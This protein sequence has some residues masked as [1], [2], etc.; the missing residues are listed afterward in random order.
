ME[1]NMVT[2]EQIQ[3]WKDKHLCVYLFEVGEKK[4]YF[5]MPTLREVEAAGEQKTSVK[6]AQTMAKSCFLGG[7]D[8]LVNEDRY[9]IP[10]MPKLDRLTKEFEVEVK[11]L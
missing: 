10:L 1:N 2:P 4:G 11:K 3:E 5:R 9:F 6:Y 8:A 7:D